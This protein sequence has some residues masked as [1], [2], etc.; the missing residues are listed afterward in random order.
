DSASSAASDGGDIVVTARRREEALQDVPISVSALSGEQLAQAGV[1]DVQG[2]Q[3]RTP[4]L[5]L[6][7]GGAQRNAMNFAMRGQRS[8]ESQLFTD[9]P[10]GTY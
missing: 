5:S 7:S 8:Q 2:L 6:T 3:Y 4:S 10:V 1:T 9:P